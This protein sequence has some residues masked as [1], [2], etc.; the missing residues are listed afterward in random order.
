[1][2]KVIGLRSYN[3]PSHP[4]TYNTTC[5][6]LQP[7]TMLR[8]LLLAALE[9]LAL[10]AAPAGGR[11][12]LKRRRTSRSSAPPK[13]F[14]PNLLVFGDSLSDDGGKYGI[15]AAQ[16]WL[17]ENPVTQPIAIAGGVAPPFLPREKDDAGASLGYVDGAW[18]NGKVWAEYLGDSMQASKVVSKFL[19]CGMLAADCACMWSMCALLELRS[20]HGLRDTTSPL[21]PQ[22]SRMAVRMVVSM[23]TTSGGWPTCVAHGRKGPFAPR[24]GVLGLL[25][26][27]SLARLN[28]L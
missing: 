5:L 14:G 28:A 23:S 3:K 22:L 15:R 4:H 18:T 19:D 16:Q 26:R 21:P 6:R 8:F 20:A 9:V 25:T 24:A 2:Q 13:T 27:G 7:Q 17:Y 11:L 1:M 10:Y 12:L